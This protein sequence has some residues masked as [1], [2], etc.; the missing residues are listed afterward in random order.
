MKLSGKKCDIF[1]YLIVVVCG[2]SK[3]TRKNKI[4]TEQFNLEL[5][6]LLP[7]PRCVPIL[8]HS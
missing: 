6:P 8:D 4:P 1:S 7:S 2:F 3:L 5:T